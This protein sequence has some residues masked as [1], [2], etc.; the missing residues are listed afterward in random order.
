MVLRRARELWS[1][2]VGDEPMPDD[3]DELTRRVLDA[4]GDDHPRPGTGT[5]HATFLSAP[6]RTGTPVAAETPWPVGPRNC[7]QSSARAEENVEPTRQNRPRTT[8]R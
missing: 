3:P 8:V 1:P 5:F 4:I 2:W 6:H 7:G